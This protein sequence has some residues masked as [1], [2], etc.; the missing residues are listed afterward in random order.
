MEQQA[1]SVGVLSSEEAVR[2]RRLFH[3]LKVEHRTKYKT[4]AAALNIE[5]DQI[6]RITTGRSS[7]T[8]EILRSVE[9]Y[10]QENKIPFPGQTDQDDQ[11]GLD[12]VLDA[13]DID[14]EIIENSVSSSAG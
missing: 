10:M 11:F 7:G 9:G 12:Y 5:V 6:Y 13:L 14:P 1:A 2:L 4:L 8:F 3:V